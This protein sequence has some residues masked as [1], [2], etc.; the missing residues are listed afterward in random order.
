MDRLADARETVLKVSRSYY[1]HLGYYEEHTRAENTT[2]R[3][4][5]FLEFAFRTHATHKVTDV[6]DVACGSGRQYLG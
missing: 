5:D 4:L 1:A 3:E 2:K 6:L